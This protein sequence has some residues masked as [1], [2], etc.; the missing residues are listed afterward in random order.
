MKVSDQ[1]FYLK[2]VDFTNTVIILTIVLIYTCT[3]T[4][5]PLQGIDSF[6]LTL[7]KWKEFLPV[8][9]DNDTIPFVSI[10]NYVPVRWHHHTD[11]FLFVQSTCIYLSI[12]LYIYLSI[13]LS[14]HLCTC[15]N[16]SIYCIYFLSAGPDQV[17]RV[18][19]C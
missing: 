16:L 18:S 14:I 3:C 2:I 10:H 5:T 12:Y 17:F 9:V 1:T 7:I 19:T 6:V 11:Y 15:I 13:Y 8:E 4:Y